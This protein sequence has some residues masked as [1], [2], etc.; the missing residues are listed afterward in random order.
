MFDSEDDRGP[1]TSL[2]GWLSEIY[3]PAILDGA[4]EA[5]AKR[6]G[7]R[8]TI[9]DALHGRTA[10]LP[11]IEHHL[12]KTQAWLEQRQA[13]FQ[14]TAFSTGIDRDVAEGML[15]LRI[16]QATVELPIAV[17]T[18]RRKSR[19]V[20][21]RVYCSRRLVGHA[22]P[23][24]RLVPLAPD[25]PLP[26]VAGDHL[27]ALRAGSLEAALD[28]FEIDGVSID[29]DGTVHRKQDGTLRK[30]LQ[31]LIGTTSP[32]P[33]CDLQRGGYADGGRT[34]ALE[35]TL[36]RLGGRD[37]TAQGGLLVYERGD[38]G[39]IRSLRAYDDGLSSPA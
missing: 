13:T 14:K 6:L 12:E 28:C 35:F 29:A 33:G 18:E 25:L 10:G 37:V 38:N 1:P 20:E 16:D 5:L 26:K 3:F 21:L 36:V 9:D 8:A 17:V 7:P 19:E 4:R 23:R 24:P 2:R 39:L 30:A 34:C 22:G 15:S 31:A 11:G 32:S 27:D